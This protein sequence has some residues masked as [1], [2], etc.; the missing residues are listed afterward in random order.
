[1][2]QRI[3]WQQVMVLSDEKLTTS[4][5]ENSHDP[6][7]VTSSTFQ[8]FKTIQMNHFVNHNWNMKNC[9]TQLAT[10]N[11]PTIFCSKLTMSQ[12]N[13]W[14]DSR[15]NMWQPVVQFCW[16]FPFFNFV[17]FI[18]EVPPNKKYIWF[19]STFFQ[20]MR[21]KSSQIQA[22]LWSQTISCTDGT[23][24]LQNVAPRTGC[25]PLSGG[26]SGRLRL[27]SLLSQRYCWCGRPL[28]VSR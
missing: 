15:P 6:W 27:H 18:N 1:M 2:K 4:F 21:I 12:H 22:Y 20:T 5:D 3:F 7:L 11:L 17:F 14:L 19:F 8:Q 23:R 25:F 13:I 28:D 16:H 24:H 10:R 9:W 26:F